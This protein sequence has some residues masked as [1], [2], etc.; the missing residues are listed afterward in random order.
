MVNLELFGGKLRAS[1]SFPTGGAALQH[2]LDLFSDKAGS[3]EWR[4]R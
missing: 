1:H 3:W 2:F 4:W